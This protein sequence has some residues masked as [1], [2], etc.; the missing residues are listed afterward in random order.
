MLISKL[1]DV[2]HIGNVTAII[3][4]DKL[5]LRTKEQSI[6]IRL[7]EPKQIKAYYLQGNLV[8]FSPASW[9]PSISANGWT[10]IFTPFG[11][12]VSFRHNKPYSTIAELVDVLTDIALFPGEFS[13]EGIIL[14]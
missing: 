10:H 7:N 9:Y 4:P 11:S 3:S 12:L 13:E 5:I 14:L 1:T 8:R 6:L 2:R